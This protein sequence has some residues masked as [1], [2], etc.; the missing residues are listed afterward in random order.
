MKNTFTI[1]DFRKEYYNEDICLDKVFKIVY[2]DAEV[3]PKCGGKFEYKRIPTRRSYQCKHCYH[4]LY[5]TQGT[6]FEK[7]KTPLME[8]FFVIF[9]FTNS[10]N[11]LSAKEVERHLGV[12]Y[13]TAWLMLNKIRTLFKQNNSKFSGIVELDET[14]IGGKNKNRHFDK[15][16]K[17]S[18]GRSHVDKKPVFGIL[19]RDGNVMAMTVRDTSAH[20][21]LPLVYRNV[22]MC[23]TIMTDEWTPYKKLSRNYIHN[24]VFHGKG[25]YGRGN[26]YTNGLENFWSVVKRT[27][28]GSYIQVSRKYLQ[29][30]IDECVFRYNNRDNKEI[31]N[32]A[33]SLISA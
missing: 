14:Y 32:H 24:K 28:N 26:C 15:K 27:I 6:I 20:S 5:P 25:E 21:I 23:S 22:Q 33:L 7:S 9:L 4:Q 1:S 18:Q 12:T 3:C 8:W 31:F 13:K 2:K 11:G 16:A 17:Y 29:T 19:E 30:Y 10:K